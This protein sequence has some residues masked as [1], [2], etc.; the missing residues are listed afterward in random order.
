MTDIIEFLTARYDEE[1]AFAR[2]FIADPG[3]GLDSW[4]D[5]ADLYY[6]H[7]AC[8]PERFLAD[9]VVRRTLLA[10]QTGLRTPHRHRPW[11]YES[12]SKREGAV[13]HFGG[14]YTV[15]GDKA[16]Q[17]ILDYSDPVTDTPT[18][19]LLVQPYANH[20]EFDPSWRTS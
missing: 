16:M 11:E 14:G 6:E 15:E 1:E 13:L 17:L 12:W 5:G 20:P 4:G 19:R 3:S 8:G 9:L 10:Q 2:A 18:L 7:G